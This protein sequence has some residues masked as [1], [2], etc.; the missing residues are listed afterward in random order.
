[1]FSPI[2]IGIPHKIYGTSLEV[3]PASLICISLRSARTGLQV[4]IKKEKNLHLCILVTF[5]M[6][7]CINVPNSCITRK[8]NYYVEYEYDEN[9]EYEYDKNVELSIY[10]PTP[11]SLYLIW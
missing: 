11:Q 6:N 4:C 1:M 8:D 9:V 7:S 2:Y 5:F 10:H 3:E